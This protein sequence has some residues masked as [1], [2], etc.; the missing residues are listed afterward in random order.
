MNA[1]GGRLLAHGRR[2]ATEIR[3]AVLVELAIMTPVL[4]LLSLGGFDA[5]RMVARENQLQSGIGEAQA[6]VLAAN[7]GASTDTNTLKSTLMSSL[8]LT[9]DQVAV[10]KL[11]RCDTS[12]TLVDSASDCSSSAVVSS[13]VRITLTDVYTPIWSQFGI[14][15]PVHYSVKRL[16]QLS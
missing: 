14:A 8:S 10:T 3:G 15:G 4:L 16:V 5:S 2:L 9:S 13:Y 7:A 11:Y 1:F 12:T 6:I